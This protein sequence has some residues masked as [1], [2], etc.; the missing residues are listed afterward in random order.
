M[1]N[2]YNIVSSSF[3]SFSRDRYSTRIRSLI[4]TTAEDMVRSGAISTEVR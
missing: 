2:K 3:L 1:N 4:E